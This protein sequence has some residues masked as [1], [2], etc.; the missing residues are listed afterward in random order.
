MPPFG[1]G[2][3]LLVVAA[4]IGAGF[5]AG[6]LNAVVGSGTLITFPI[7]VAVGVPPLAATLTNSVGLLPSNFT[8]AWGYRR[9]LAVQRD[10]L[11]LLLPV[12]VTGGLTGSLLLVLLPAATFERVAPLLI[13]TAVALVIAQ[14]ALQRVAQRRRESRQGDG[15]RQPSR[16]ALFVLMYAASV[17]GGYFVAAQGVFM[18]GIMGVLLGGDL[19]LINALKSV[20]ASTVNVVA[21][22]VYVSS[23]HRTIAWS[24]AAAIAVGAAAGGLIGARF[25]RLI[26]G[27]VLRW[28]LVAAGAS[29]LVVLTLD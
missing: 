20:L 25:G 6:A 2:E 18:F 15:R 9:L 27:T 11:A 12:A 19:R 3:E 21:S 7:L 28:L 24:A 29:A 4:L 26:P 14:P 5:L 1:S 22:I 17:Y 13:V 23:S 10:R 8:S 16:T